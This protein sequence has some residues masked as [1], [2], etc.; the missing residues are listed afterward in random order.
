MLECRFVWLCLA[1][2]RLWRGPDFCP[3]ARKTLEWE[4]A[5]HAERYLLEGMTQ[6]EALEIMKTGASVFLTGEPG[7]GKTHTVNSF[8]AWLKAR[9]IETAVT[10]STGI[11][12]THVG[13]STIHS[14]CGIGIKRRLTQSDLARIAANPRV[15]RRVRAIK[16]LV[17][18][19]ISMLGAN[20]F[21]MIE[22]V[23]RTLRGGS[24]PFGGLQLVL[25]GD[26]FQ[27]PPIVS[28]EEDDG[29]GMSLPFSGKPALFA[30]ESPAWQRLNPVVL[31]LSEQHRQEDQVFL[32]FLSAVRRR[33]VL[34]THHALLETRRSAQPLAGVTQL[35]A[36]NVD[37]DAVNLAEL[38]KLA[39]EPRSFRMTSRGPEK[40][41]AQLKKGCLSPEELLLKIGARVMC[42][43]NDTDRRFVNGTLGTV[44]GF[45]KEAGHPMVTTW[46]GRKIVVEPEEWRIEEGDRV[47]AR[48]SQ[49]PLRLAWAIT[50]HKSQGMSLDAAH[51]DLSSAF[52][53]GQG[54]VAL[55]RVRT[56]RG[57]SL[58]DWNERA[59]EVHPAIS[60]RDAEFREASRRAGEE[61][62]R[63]APAQLLEKQSDFVRACGGRIAEPATPAA[64]VSRPDNV[65]RPAKPYSLE[66]LREA[67]PNAYA[68]WRAEEDADLTRR[69]RAGEKTADIAHA[70][71]RQRGAIRARLKKL[72]LIQ[73]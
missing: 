38:G 30:F 16:V 55:S 5:P 12:A 33:A 15:R 14:F 13:G 63:T 17:I 72:G 1:S 26:F 67:Y 46:D 69:Y 8:V 41:V 57:L 6:R 43:K 35:F 36:H 7:S 11:A 61:L 32:E 62:A 47:L 56:L 22:A 18:D 59:L 42:T 68:P 25:V 39:G 58:V 3:S 54:Y 28:F 4:H 48:I 9:G 44:T 21:G 64:A 53:H 52:E 65:S 23:C 73:D 27:L 49:V 40:L 34:D 70:F 10:A 24:Q 2:A 51:I 66:K 60:S 45:S 31:Y 19:E 50:V 37:V 71:G 20:T 29:E